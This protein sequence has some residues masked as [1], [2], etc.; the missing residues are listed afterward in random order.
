MHTNFVLICFW[1]F[2]CTLVPLI[3]YVL[4]NLGRAHS[5]MAFCN[6]YFDDDPCTS[7]MSIEST[8]IYSSCKSLYTYLSLNPLPI[9]IPYGPF[10]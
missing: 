4:D 7:S 3:V 2:L 1:I 9:H 6:H 8:P 5:P 10:P